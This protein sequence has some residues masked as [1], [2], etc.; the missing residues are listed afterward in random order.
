MVRRSLVA[1]VFLLPALPAKAQV[2]PFIIDQ[3][4]TDRTLPAPAPHQAPVAPAQ[5]DDKLA[6]VTPFQ[7]TGI[8]VEGTSLAPALLGDATRAF[9]GKTMDA[10]A[11]RDVAAAVSAAYAGQG[12][13]ALYTVTVPA[14]DFAGGVLL[15]RV[16]EGFISHVD[17]A[18]GR[19]L[20][21][22]I[23]D[24]SERKRIEAE[25]QRAN[26]AREQAHRD[27]EVRV[28]YRTAELGQ[29]NQQ[30]QQQSELFGGL[31]GHHPGAAIGSQGE[32]GDLIRQQGQAGLRQQGSRRV[33]HD[34]RMAAV[35]ERGAERGQLAGLG[36]GDRRIRRQH[37]CRGRAS[38][39][40]W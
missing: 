35:A 8:R 15:L 2:S 36:N 14:Q 31:R 24:I 17:L 5:P 22:I 18:G 1:A 27:L 13:I 11:I 9:V 30:L 21:G 26:R 12:D 4:R 38:Q 34:Q 7:L 6:A 23:R 3:N 37:A 19:L 10:A 32:A 20:T 40:Q 28:E 25:L 29:A 39:Q 33:L 16:T